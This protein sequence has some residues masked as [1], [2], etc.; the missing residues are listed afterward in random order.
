MI[1]AAKQAGSLYG[2]SILALYRVDR[3]D[4][5]PAEQADTQPT[6]RRGEPSRGGLTQHAPSGSDRSSMVVSER[7]A[8]MCAAR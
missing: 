8:G 7:R 4:R 1:K 3:L 5:H 6:R 2:V